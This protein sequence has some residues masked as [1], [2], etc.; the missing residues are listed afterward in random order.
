MGRALALVMALAG[1]AGTARADIYTFTDDRGV[2]HFTNIERRGGRWRR[3]MRTGPGKA[4][5]VHARYRRHLPRDRYTRYDALIA[6][7]AE[8]YRIPEALVRAIIHVESDFDPR[9]VSRVGARGL[10]Q[11]MPATARLVGVTAVH[12]AA[13]NIFGGVRF[14]R[15]LANRFAGNLR[16]TIAAYHAGPGAV[17][18][19]GGVPPYRT[20]HKYL[21]MVLSR[22][23]AYRA[24]QARGQPPGRG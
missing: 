16:L 15:M 20:T 7:A 9:A 22:F 4:R 24:S 1:A 10:M 13:Q 23:R 6:R 8:R 3:I 2:V 19:Y 12:D 11:L 21:R 14:L 5:V 17:D 18:R